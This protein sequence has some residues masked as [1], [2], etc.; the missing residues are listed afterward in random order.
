MH[1]FGTE[2]FG[3]DI[4][5]SDHRTPITETM[6][7]RMHQSELQLSQPPYT[8]LAEEKVIAL[9]TKLCVPNAGFSQPTTKRSM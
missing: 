5:V 9:E 8:G 3:H 2:P 6:D 7:L 4:V 1:E